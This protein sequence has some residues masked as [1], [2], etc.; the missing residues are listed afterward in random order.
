[1]VS[2]SA[3]IVSGRVAAGVLENGLDA[4]RPKVNAVTVKEPGPKL[5][6]V[7]GKTLV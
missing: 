7:K 3:A 1:V 6:N 4:P 2:E 5:I